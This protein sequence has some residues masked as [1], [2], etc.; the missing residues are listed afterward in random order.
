MIAMPKRAPVRPVNVSVPTASFTWRPDGSLLVVPKEPLGPYPARFTAHLQ[1]WAAARPGAAPVLERGPDGAWHGPTYPDVLAA[2][3]AVGQALLDR[4]LGPDRPVALLSG[5]G[6]KHLLLMLGAM[7]V[8]VPV[9]PIS[10]A[11][12][13]GGGP[14]AKLRHCFGLLQPGLVVIDGPGQARA[15]VEALAPGTELVTLDGGTLDDWP[16]TPYADLLHTVPTAAVERAAAAVDAGTVAKILFT[17][18]S[19]GAPKG[20]ITTHGMLSSNQQ[21]IL[22]AFP[23]MADAPPVLVDWL[24]W[25]HTFGGNHNLGLVLA[26]GGTLHV[27]EGRPA[28]G[29]FDATAAN[30]RDVAP[31]MYFNVPLGY[32]QLADRLDADSALRERFFSRLGLL[33]YAAA[34]LPQPLW[35]RLDA[36]AVRT[37]G[38]RIQWLTGMGSTETAPFCLT[39]RPD[40]GAGIVGLPAAGVDLKLAP[41]EGKM[42][43]RVRG[44][45][46]TPGYWR[47]PAQTAKLFDDEGYLCLGDALVPAD[48]ENYDLGFR[49]DGRVA[50]DFKLLSGTWVSVGPLRLRL[51]EALSPHV[52][53]LVIAGADRDELGVLAIPHRA[54]AAEDA[55]V[56]AAVMAALVRHAEGAPSSA[57]I[58]R[59]MWLTAPLSIEAGELTDKGSVN[60]R[61][62]LRNHAAKVEMLYSDHPGALRVPAP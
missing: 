32:Q 35:D 37:I 21:M 44:P 2:M 40:T 26:N 54:E 23:M 20:V 18:G 4:G 33:F 49:F 43:A 46:V 22:Q 8:G 55:A 13:R 52:K 11:Y 3:R 53:D 45:N 14:F 62:V 19:T 58:A 36:L 16:T 42:E 7:H 34:S 28:P 56:R 24:P 38:Q 57:R 10:T 50:E 1:H 61:G 30:L 15:V 48:P 9:S 41:L 6:I 25:N 47:D 5:N 39:S 31:T 51:L 17:S 12:S 29:A 59:L 60:Q 27:D